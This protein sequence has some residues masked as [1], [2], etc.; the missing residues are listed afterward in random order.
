MTVC[1][2][3]MIT[4]CLHVLLELLATCLLLLERNAYTY[5]GYTIYACPAVVSGNNKHTV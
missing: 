2:D 1:M 4:I 5:T 3:H